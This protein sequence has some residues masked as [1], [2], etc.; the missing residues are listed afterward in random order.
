[1]DV[2]VLVT[3]TGPQTVR[4]TIGGVPVTKT[5][6]Q[7]NL[8]SAPLSFGFL[9]E[10]WKQKKGADIAHAHALYIQDE[11]AHIFLDSRL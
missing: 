5:G 11:Q 10:V 3:N 2:R 9:P 1:M 6:R 8:S 4:E 7:A